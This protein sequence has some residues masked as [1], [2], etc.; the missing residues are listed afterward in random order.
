MN[1]RHI[2]FSSSDDKWGSSSDRG[3]DTSDSEVNP[4]GKGYRPSTKN[5]KPPTE[6]Q[7]ATNPAANWTWNLENVS[8][9]YKISY[10]IVK[11][12]FLKWFFFL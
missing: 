8:V 6:A 9:I 11:W 2:T 3:M 4:Q 7:P 5:L 12:N 10:E 1:H